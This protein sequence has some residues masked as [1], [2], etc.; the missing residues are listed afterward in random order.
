MF[1]NPFLW[2]ALVFTIVLA[3]RIRIAKENERFAVH[4]LGQFKGFKGPGIHI[5]F[6][7][8][9]IEWS[10]IKAD[11]RGKV[12]T[13]EMLRIGEND[14][15]FKSDNQVRL[16]DYVRISGFEKEHAIVVIDN[17]QRNSFVC[18]KCGHQNFIR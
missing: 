3:A 7:G 1:E 9:E 15:P 11:D 18:E 14:I 10:R 5:K 17:D 13:N 4:I 2:I 8:K 16:G 12:V 6:S